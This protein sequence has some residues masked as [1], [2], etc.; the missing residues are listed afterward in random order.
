MTRMWMVKP[1][2]LCRNH[3]L[4][5]HKEIHQAIGSIIKGKSIKG[6]IEKGQIEVHNLKNRHKQLVKE[7]KRRGYKHLSPLKK[8]KSYNA[9][10]IDIQK[11]YAELEKRCKNCRK[12][13]KEGNYKE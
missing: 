12:L 5:E 11:N 9:G 8:F 2:Y 6:H 13:I 4:G 7:L 1:E 10:K 3:L